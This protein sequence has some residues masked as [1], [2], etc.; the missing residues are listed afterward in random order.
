LFINNW[1]QVFKSFHASKHDCSMSFIKFS[2]ALSTLFIYLIV[3][4]IWSNFQF[5]QHVFLHLLT[6]YH[7]ERESFWN[8][9]GKREKFPLEWVVVIVSKRRDENI[10][11]HRICVLTSSIEACN[12]NQL[13]PNRSSN[14]ILYH[15]HQQHN[16]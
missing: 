3:K 13:M 7:R 4:L 15:H 2:A 8:F 9:H 12:K 1:N 16:T 14:I 5:I 11:F 10:Y 6:V